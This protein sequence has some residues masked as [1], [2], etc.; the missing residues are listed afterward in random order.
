[1]L[2]AP[3]A[4]LPHRG[5]EADAAPSFSQSGDAPALRSRSVSLPELVPPASSSQLETAP[6]ISTLEQQFRIANAPGDRET[7]AAEIAGWNDTSAVLAIQR[8]FRT[9]RHPKVKVA[10]LANLAD[11]NADASLD[12]RLSLLTAA[13]HGQP[14]EVRMAALDSLAQLDDPRVPLAL[15]QTITADPDHEV[16]ELATALHRSRFGDARR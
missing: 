3:V 1:M 10:L 6:S 11:I 2:S 7:L 9:E 4:P 5:F 14:R 16:R 13:L 12:A 15:K 8:L